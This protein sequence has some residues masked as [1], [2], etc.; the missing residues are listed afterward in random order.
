MLAPEFQGM[1]LGLVLADKGVVWGT[2]MFFI[3]NT[4]LQGA[5]GKRARMARD[6]L[7]ARAVA[8]GEPFYT[9]SGA[10]ELLGIGA[11]ADPTDTKG[12]VVS[13]E[14]DFG[15]QGIFE[16][17][18]ESEFRTG[19]DTWEKLFL[20]KTK[21]APQGLDPEVTG[22]KIQAE[23][24][25]PTSTPKPTTPKP[26][27]PKPTTPKPTSGTPTNTTKSP[28]S[29]PKTSDVVVTPTGEQGSVEKQTPTEQPT[30]TKTP[31]APKPAD[32][33]SSKAGIAIGVVLGLLAVIGIA[34]AA[35][36]MVAPDL[37]RQ[38][39]IPGA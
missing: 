29:A 4:P 20:D 22:A 1:G 3:D 38:L 34:V 11:V 37:A 32:E 6:P 5:G 33:G 8:S 9:P 31:K 18:A 28:A 2:T 12:H 26:S 35:L 36:P 10:R 13:R 27:T 23:P 25:K 39:G 19:P 17:I 15:E 24:V 16:V 21:D 7:T 14:V 30:S